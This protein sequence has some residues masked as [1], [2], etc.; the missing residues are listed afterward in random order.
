[1]SK[2]IFNSLNNEDRILALKEK[3][4]INKEQVKLFKDI[5][6]NK[7]IYKSNNFEFISDGF[8]SNI[9]SYDD[10]IAIYQIPYDRGFKATN[11]GKSTDIYNINNGF[12]GI[13]INK[14]KNNI[15]V[16]YY[17]ISSIYID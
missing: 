3:I 4:I 6:P 11:N 10:T 8:K 9:D 14:G 17:I 2:D 13:R 1:M 7:T 16:S 15:I 5:Y 12:I